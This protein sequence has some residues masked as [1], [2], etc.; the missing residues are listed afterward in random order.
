MS[1]YLAAIPST[2]ISVTY[3]DAERANEAARVLRALHLG[4]RREA[5][6][7]LCKVN[8][9]TVCSI[10]VRAMTTCVSAQIP[11]P[12]WLQRKPADEDERD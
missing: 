10:K 11:I 12:S 4:L 6:G 7:R 2:P 5:V 8:R 1:T 9:R 3:T